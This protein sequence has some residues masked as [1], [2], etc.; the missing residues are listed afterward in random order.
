MI[1]SVAE[2]YVHAIAMEREAAERYAEF[3]G[4]MA[5]EGNAQVAALFG[6]LA[7]LEAGHLEALRR[8]TEGVALPELESDYSWIDTGAPE[9]LAH[10]L[11]FR[12]MTPHQALG[13]ALRA[14]KRAKAFFEQ[15]R[16]V[17]DDPALR[18]LAQEMAAEEA[19]HIAMLEKQLARTPEGVVDWASIYESG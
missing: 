8:R 15:A 14:E 17:A 16:R 12:L 19:G 11:V 2:L 1:E 6:R 7:A 13:V 10:D 3:A 4:R 18:A 5:D 9:T